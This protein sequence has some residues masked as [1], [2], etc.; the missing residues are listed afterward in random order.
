MKN[1]V[2]NIY[3]ILFILVGMMAGLLGPL[4]PYLSE[5]ANISIAK[6]GGFLSLFAI[7]SMT[8]A[9]LSD[10][11]LLLSKP[12]RAIAFLL[13]LFG[14]EMGLFY[15]SSAYA[16]YLLLS[17]LLGATQ[18]VINSSGNSIMLKV[19]KE[20][21][22]PKITTLHFFYGVGNIIIPLLIVGSA[23]YL[24]NDSYIF[25]LLVL[26]S[27]PL[28]FTLFYNQIP[29]SKE[30][31]KD[32]ILYDKRSPYFLIFLSLFALY[33]GI[34]LTIGGWITT[35]GIL[36]GTDKD[37]AK[38]LPSIFWGFLTLG[39]LLLI[40]VIKVV[41]DRKILFSASILAIVSSSILLLDSTFGIYLAPALIGLSVSVY[42][43]TLYSYGSKFYNLEGRNTGFIFISAGV[44]GVSMPYI[45]GLFIEYFGALS[46]SYIIVLLLTIWFLIFFGLNKRLR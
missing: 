31:E 15:I 34:E 19:W 5:R 6:A 39:R 11:I 23:I 20:E 18:G 27:L 43:P 40:Y 16:I 44:G 14:L 13:L 17:F 22:G 4:I 25:L 35:Y 36:K 32:K 10:R 41:P 42:F 3:Y 12:S 21:A 8:G 45:T 24:R 30:S 9:Y 1:K 46:L 37:T 26:I 7:G 2:T 28:A 33:V 38:T 29:K